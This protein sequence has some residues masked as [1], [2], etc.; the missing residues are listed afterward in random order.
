MAKFDKLRERILSKPNDFTW[1]ELV[2]L[3]GH[4]GYKEVNTGKTGGSRRKFV[5]TTSKHVIS[6]HKPHPG[7]ILKSYQINQVIATLKEQGLIKDE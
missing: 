2:T 3:L 4:F 5:E 7:K 1:D 6:L